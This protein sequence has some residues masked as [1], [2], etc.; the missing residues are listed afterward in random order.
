MKTLAYTIERLGRQWRIEYKATGKK[1]HLSGS[2]G[3]YPHRSDALRVF[4]N[5]CE[6]HNF[7]TKEE[8]GEA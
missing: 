3:W 8:G 7:Y 1:M 6:A 5:F 4:R 2:T